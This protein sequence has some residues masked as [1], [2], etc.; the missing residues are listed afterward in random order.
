MAKKSKK[1]K[2]AAGVGAG[3][4]TLAAAGA[5]AYLFYGSKNASKNRRKVS[6]WTRKAKREVAAE[7][8]KVKKFDQAAY[9]KAVN[10][11]MNRYA[12]LNHV[13][14][15]ELAMLVKLARGQWKNIQKHVAKS[16]TKGA[17]KGKK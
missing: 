13:D 4:A 3:V 1:V 2:I 16:Q 14:K 8:E 9:H 5:A 7:L 15:K 6:A 10:S 11:V 12:K 17:K